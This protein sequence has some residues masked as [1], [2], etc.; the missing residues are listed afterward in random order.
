MLMTSWKWDKLL[1]FK[2]HELSFTTN[3]HF[4]YFQTSTAYLCTG[5]VSVEIVIDK[6]YNLVSRSKG[7]TVV[8]TKEI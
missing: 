8:N 3:F 6:Q 5:E 7:N 1:N 2:V 4:I